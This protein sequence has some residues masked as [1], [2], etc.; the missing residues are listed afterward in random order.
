[1]MVETLKLPPDE[2]RP[3]RV[4]PRLN[5]RIWLLMWLSLAG[6]LAAIG[7]GGYELYRAQQLRSH[8][9]QIEGTL[10][11]SSK[12]STGKGRTA[13]SV[14]LNYQPPTDATTYQKQFS[15][16]ESQFNEIR[17]NG[18]AQVTYL[19]ADPTQSAV[20]GIVKPNYEPLAMGIGLLAVSG[21]IAL[22]RR[23]QW[24]QVETY[25]HG[26]S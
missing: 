21:G 5:R 2:P 11:D 25:I 22:Y 23:R 4:Y 13:F 3:P 20:G 15:V 26:K 1:M 16:T 6:G 14:T 17:Q 19:A 8:G 24:K 9:Q 18:K 7:G 10:V 12:L